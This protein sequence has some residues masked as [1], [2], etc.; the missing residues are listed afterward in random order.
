MTCLK[1]ETEANFD[2]ADTE[3]GN[4]LDSGEIMAQ[5]SDP[6]KSF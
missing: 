4:D 5:P 2:A 3:S 1:P 6:S